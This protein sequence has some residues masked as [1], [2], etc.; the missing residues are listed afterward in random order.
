[1]RIS[2]SIAAVLSL[3]VVFTR[4]DEAEA[5]FTEKGQLE[6]SRLL[7]HRLT[8]LRAALRRVEALRRGAAPAQLDEGDELLH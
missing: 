2:S 1:M 3:N 8:V 6:L 4:D 7:L 5:P